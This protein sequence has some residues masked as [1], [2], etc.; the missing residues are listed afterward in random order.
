MQQQVTPGGPEMSNIS[1]I[2]RLEYSLKQE[3]NSKR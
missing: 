3:W 2:T 1:T